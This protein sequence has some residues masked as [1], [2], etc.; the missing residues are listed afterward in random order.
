MSSRFR[1][2]YSALYFVTAFATIA[3][4]DPQKAFDE[5]EDRVVD[6]SPIPDTGG[7]G[8]FDI[9]GEYLLSIQTSLGT[10][11]RFALT[12]VFTPS[13]SGGTVNWTFQPLKFDGCAPTG[14]GGTPVGESLQLDGVPV[15]ETGTFDVTATGTNV[16][17]QAVPGLCPVDPV[18]ADI[19]LIGAV[20]SE[21]LFC[22][23][24]AGMVLEPLETTLAGSTFGAVKLA[25][26]GVY[27]DANLPASVIECPAGG[28]APR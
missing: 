22:G 12:S 25:E 15:S 8:V 18:V 19:Q 16:D 26:P 21:D 14:N 17:G 28:E 24:V 20:R 2:S 7:G 23:D 5:F 13:E 4:V 27:G 9:T 10:Q 6:A 1:L 11:L 3:C